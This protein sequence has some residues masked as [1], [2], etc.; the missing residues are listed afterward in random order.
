MDH[1]ANN[2]QGRE[3]SAGGNKN[4]DNNIEVLVKI[5]QSNEMST[6]Q[7]AEKRDSSDH[8]QIPKDIDGEQKRQ[9]NGKNYTPKVNHNATGKAAI[10][11]HNQHDHNKPANLLNSENQNMHEKGSHNIQ[12]DGNEQTMENINKGNITIDPR[13]PPPIKVSSNF[14]TYKSSHPKTNQFSPKMNQN[15]PTP[16][17]FGNNNT[18]SQIPEPSP[19][20]VVHSLAT[21]L[22]ANQAKNTI[23]III[24]PP[25]VASRQGR[26]SVT[27]YEDD[28]MINMAA[29]CKYTLVGKFINVMPKMEVIR[30]SFSAQ[31]HLTG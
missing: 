22:R 10:N 9:E 3:Q 19:L 7:T 6:H 25:I 27:F 24:N 30:R 28:F 8:N 17:S 20:T 16:N 1:T 15:R 14:D 31:T 26:P 18:K 4:A 2:P 13:I 11:V 12:V 21:R 23:P 5:P 29:R